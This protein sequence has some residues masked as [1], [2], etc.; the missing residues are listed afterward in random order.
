[1]VLLKHLVQ[2]EHLDL[3]DTLVTNSGLVHLEALRH[4]RCINLSY[5]GGAHSKGL[6]RHTAVSRLP[7][8]QCGQLCL[9]CNTCCP[10]MD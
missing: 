1:M 6:A 3:S 10:L 2:L 9:P 8:L 4:I 5:A 7:S